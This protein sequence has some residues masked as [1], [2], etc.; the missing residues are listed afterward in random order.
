[1]G[2][3]YLKAG[4]TSR[5]A[6]YFL[7]LSSNAF[8]SKTIFC[9]SSKALDFGDTHSFALNWLNGDERTFEISHDQSIY[10]YFEGRKP[11]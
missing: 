5:K 2:F 4:A 8:L 3:I 9:N 7:P 6:V 10:V 11:R 1:M